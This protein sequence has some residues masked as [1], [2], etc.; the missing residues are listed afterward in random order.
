MKVVSAVFHPLL[1]ATYACL[2][3]WLMFPGFYSPLTSKAIPYVILAI[4]TTTF[5]IPVMSVLL[6][7]SDQEN[8]QS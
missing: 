1:M 6:I 4:F 8:H 2:I 3:L 7:A 5:V